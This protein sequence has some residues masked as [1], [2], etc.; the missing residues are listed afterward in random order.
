MLK[1]L[2]NELNKIKKMKFKEKIWYIKEY[3]LIQIIIFLFIFLFIFSLAKSL[4][5]KHN[6]LNT[7]FINTIIDEN[8]KPYIIE[9]FKKFANLN[10]NSKLFNLDTQIKINFNETLKTPLNSAYILKL[11]SLISAREVDCIFAEK[12]AIDYYLT[13]DAFFPIN[14][15]LSKD[16]LKKYKD[17]LYIAKNKDNLEKPFAIKI[18][19]NKFFNN[20]GIENDIYFTIPKN[21]KNIDI[22]LKF[23]EYIN[24]N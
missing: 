3:Y 12:E 10:N 22:A 23:F 2:K 15:I 20:L 9:D 11:T 24:Q 13:I 8:M 5:K 17:N 18:S 1:N 16:L 4:F 7:Y 21:A 14:E 6:I 19:N